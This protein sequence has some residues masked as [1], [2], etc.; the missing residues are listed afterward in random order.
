LQRIK[1]KAFTLRG[2]V[3]ESGE[4][5]SGSLP[6]GLEL[7]ARAAAGMGPAWCEADRQSSARPLEND[8][9][10]GTP[11]RSIAAPW[12]LDGPIDGETFTTY[13]EKILLPIL[14]PGDVV[15]MDNLGSHRGK[16]VRRLTAQLAPSCSSC[17]NTHRT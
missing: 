2:L 5:A 16:A 14:K 8:F 11:Q 4:R 1:E 17:R 10:G 9:C 3:A 6:V 15:V 13:G 7:R 12:L